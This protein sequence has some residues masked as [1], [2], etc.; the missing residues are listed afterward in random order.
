MS[1]LAGFVRDVRLKSPSRIASQLHLGAGRNDVGYG[2]LNR[3]DPMNQPP[4]R[5]QQAVAHAAHHAQRPR[6]ELRQAAGTL[7]DPRDQRSA[8]PPSPDAARNCST[9]PRADMALL[10]SPA[11]R[12]GWVTTPIAALNGSAVPDSSRHPLWDG[13]RDATPCRVASVR[14]S[15]SLKVVREAGR[16]GDRVLETCRSPCVEF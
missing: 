11:C 10:G 2:H 9:R 16:L 15:E 13:V 12:C 6:L 7:A 3:L 5:P 8:I 4:N 1:S 14:P